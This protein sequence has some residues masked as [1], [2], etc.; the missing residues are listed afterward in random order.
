[1]YTIRSQSTTIQSTSRPLREIC[2]GHFV[3]CNDAEFEKYR[4]IVSQN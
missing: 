4:K 1:M 3:Q 2:D